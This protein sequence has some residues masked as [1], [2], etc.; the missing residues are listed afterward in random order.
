MEKLVEQIVLDIIKQQ[1]QLTDEQIWIFNQN[2]KIPNTKGL[3]VV[4]GFDDASGG[5]ISNTN[6]VVSTEA[7]MTE[8]QRVVARVGIRV[9]ILSR[10]NSALNR[11]F[12]ILQAIKSVYS[13]QQQEKN[14]FKIFGLPSLFANTSSA[15]GGSMLNRFTIIIICH[16]WQLKEIV[17]NSTNGDFYTEFKTRADDEATIG[18]DEGIFEFT[19]TE[20]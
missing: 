5:I 20:E 18:S 16:A 4:V 2:I 1:M 13:Q 7:G 9:D 15:E 3:F 19:I 14:S 10:D 6:T 11:K 8:E 12:E 17:L